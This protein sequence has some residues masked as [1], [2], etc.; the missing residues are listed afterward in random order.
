[1]LGS[2][3]RRPWWQVVI[4]LLVVVLVVAPNV[5]LI[6]RS[7]GT[8][9]SGGVAVDWH[10]FTEAGRRVHSDG[11]YEITADYGFRYSPVLALFFGVIAPMGEVAW[12][13]LHVGAAL[14]LPTWPMRLVTLALWPFWF[15]VEAG[16]VIVFVLLAAAWALRGNAAGIGA[17][18]VLFVL[19]PRPLMLPVLAWLLWRHPASRLPFVGLFVVHLVAVL[20]TGWGGEWVSV[21][22]ASGDEIG[23]VLNLGPSRFIGVAWVVIGLPLAAWLTWRGRLGWASLAAS[24]YW[25]PYYLLMPVLEL[26]RGRRRGA[27]FA[28]GRK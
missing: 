22:L 3:L 28:P 24:P 5:W 20:A 27:G 11:L 7:L 21:L 13:L 8:I 18:M 15:D 1:M 26:D 10:H 16:N 6:G 17:F 4:G 23:S 14:A 19:M 2:I 12:R 9:L 25:L